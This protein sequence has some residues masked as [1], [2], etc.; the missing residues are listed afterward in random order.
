MSDPLLIQ[1]FL[2]PISLSKLMNDEALNESQWGTHIRL[3]EED[4]PDLKEVDIVLLGIPE[5]RGNGFNIFSSNGADIIRKEFFQSY[6]W[7][8]DIRIADIGNI[9][10]GQN[11]SDTY[12][13][14]R[15][16]IKTLLAEKI[17]VILIGGSHD[18][19]LAQYSAYAE[20]KKL[21][22]VVCIDA[23]INLV[24]E[25]SIKS[26]NFLMEML[27]GEP[28]FI[29]TY[30]HLAFQSY[31]VHPS[32]LQTMDKLGFDCYRVGAVKEH[33]MEM[34][35]VLRSTQLVSIDMSALAHAYAPGSAI[36]PNGLT[37]EEMCT[38]TRFA[39]MS[40]QLSTLGIYG[41][42]AAADPSRQTAMQIAQMIWYFIDGKTKAA[43]ESSLSDRD[44][45]NE[46]HT[47]FNEIEA[48]FLQSKRTGRWWMQL[49]D[50]KIIPCSERDYRLAAQNE[51]PERWFRAQE[52]E[53]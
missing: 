37:G 26:E 2:Q 35:P 4:F 1:D 7:H 40:Q 30:H 20:I 11:I 31:Y 6:Q 22:E 10:T 8:P 15:T 14:I 25:S 12:A 46:F 47:A 13:A 36:S 53:F 44:D 39:G 42:N 21:I 28:N 41:Y 5:E 23:L 19:T 16:V 29:K 33:L 45:F 9:K 3:Y 50:G 38:L 17:T 51:I 48:L 34:E 32:M 49:P 27:T 52:R 24:G 18:I 43:T